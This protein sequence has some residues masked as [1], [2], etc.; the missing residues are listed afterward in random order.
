MNKRDPRIAHFTLALLAF[1]TSQV[2]L[3]ILI[4]CI[5]L[6]QPYELLWLRY[7]SGHYLQIAE[8][9]YEIFPCAGR[10][11]YPPDAS[12]FC[13][14]TGWFPGYPL[15]LNGL[16][17]LFGDIVLVAGIVSKTFLFLS[18]VILLEL[19]QTNEID[20]RSYVIACI[21][22][23]WFGS[24]YYSAIFPISAIVFFS[25]CGILSIHRRQIWPAAIACF[26]SSLFYP[27]GI[28]L[29]IVL[30]LDVLFLKDAIGTR[31]IASL[32]LI[33]SGI[34]GLCVAFYTIYTQTHVWDAFL[35]V[36]AKYG[37][38]WND[39]FK[40]MAELLRSIKF[41]SVESIPDIQT[42]ILIGFFIGL[43]YLYFKRRSHRSDLDTVILL[44]SW[45]YLSFPWFIG[46][47]LSMYRAE[48][49][50]MPMA[51]ASKDLQMKWLI[52]VLIVLI[53]LFIPM[54]YLFFKQVLI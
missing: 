32:K 53:S 39:P 28:L 7:D 23:F 43:N 1:L 4:A 42:L 10:F 38:G 25:L 26:L 9:G 29:C 17:Y 19:T 8:K 52:A 15:L 3:T 44:F 40:R 22:G 6:D 12:E 33:A 21:G 36:Q 14:N 47:D 49:L 41:N 24:I 18:L 37:H 35:K 27:T 16:S 46:G 13:G 20:L 34:I 54:S 11:G 51:V 31:M 5:D 45:I 48:A 30:A 50:L 2:A